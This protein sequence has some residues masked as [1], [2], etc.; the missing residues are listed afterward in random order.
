MLVMGETYIATNAAWLA[1]AHSVY[2]H[3]TTAFLSIQSTGIGGIVKYIF[4]V[5]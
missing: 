4:A 1:P 2:I 5:R 3:Y